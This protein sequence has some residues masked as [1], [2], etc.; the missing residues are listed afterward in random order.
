[1]IFFVEKMRQTLARLA[2]DG[3]GKPK[4]AWSHYQTHGILGNVGQG[5]HYNPTTHYTLEQMK[6]KSVVYTD[7]YLDGYVYQNLDNFTPR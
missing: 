7:V 6:K 2:L 4:G 5:R 3:H 1:M